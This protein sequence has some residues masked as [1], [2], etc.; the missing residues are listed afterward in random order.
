MSTY[1]HEEFPAPDCANC[2]HHQGNGMCGVGS[3]AGDDGVCNNHLYRPDV[4]SSVFTPVKF[5]RDKL[6]MEYE[7][8]VNC[9]DL[10]VDLGLP[11]RKITLASRHIHALFHEDSDRTRALAAQIEEKLDSGFYTCKP[12]S[13]N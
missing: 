9:A 8:I 5:H 7:Y 6:A 1:E 13:T 4:I 12:K 11:L 10:D 3:T 2:G